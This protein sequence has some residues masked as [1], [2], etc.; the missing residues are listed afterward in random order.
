MDMIETTNL[1]KRFG[2]TTAVNRVSF[3]VRK[4]EV[5][6]FLGPNG[7]GKTTTMRLLTCFMQPDEGTAKL[8]GNDIL[9]KPLE[10]RKS[11]GYLPESAPLYM[12]MGVI[13]YLSY[14]AEVRGI[15]KH[16][17]PK[18]VRKMVEVCGLGDVLKKDI[19]HL[20]RGYRQRVGL[21]QTMIHE[22]PILILDEPTSGLD[23]NQIM[24][25][26][27]LIKE[28]GRE[29]TVVLSTHILPEVEAT[30]NRVIIINEGSIVASGTPDE[31]AARSSKGATVMIGVRGP[32]EEVRRRLESHPGVSRV[33]VIGT[34]N[35]VTRFAVTAAG[36]RDI[37]E[38]LFRV[39]AE[40]HWSCNELHRET[41]TLEDVFS[42]L[43]MKEK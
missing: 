8:S 43:T 16:D 37:T 19:G 34:A 38:D 23:P 10:V 18:K 25:I 22:P 12:D 24:E 5:L 3:E 39:V 2:P 28:L 26:R 7:A 14:I 9:E 15:P 35:G 31:L 36:D 27:T 29:K 4:G 41:A 20:S 17:R 6:G 21:A 1:V 30:C 13:E 40:N 33:K 42:R 11:I 32:E